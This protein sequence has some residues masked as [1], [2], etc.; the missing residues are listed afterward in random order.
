MR[1]MNR[2]AKGSGCFVCRSC[3]R[4]TRETHDNASLE[5]CPDCVAL[6]EQENRIPDCGSAPDAEAEVA[7]LRAKIVAKGGRLS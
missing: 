6:T 3:R 5:L 1:A 4:R 7:R 2:F